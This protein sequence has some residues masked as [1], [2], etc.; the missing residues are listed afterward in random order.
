MPLPSPDEFK[1]R[2]RSLEFS[3]AML[4]VARAGLANLLLDYPPDHPRV[5]DARES[6]G[7]WTREVERL[8]HDEEARL[9]AGAA[10]ENGLPVET[11]A[12]ESPELYH[13]VAPA[14]NRGDSQEGNA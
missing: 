11:R 12:V 3:R 1:T 4:D 6:V 14:V 9:T 8:E 7:G 2:D 5:R 10:S 13:T